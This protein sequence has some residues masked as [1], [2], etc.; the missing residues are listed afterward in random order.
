MN[1]EVIKAIVQQSRQDLLSFCVYTD[2]FYEIAP[3]HE[4]IAEYLDKVLNGEIQNLI[5]EMP[6]RSWKSR[7]MQ[8]FI[9]KLYWD[10]P[11]VDVLYTGHSMSLLEWFSRNIRNRINDD[12]YKTLYNTKVAWDSSAV[13]NWNIANGWE[14]AVFWVWGWITGKGWNIMVIDDPYS[15]REQAESET[16]R[17]KVSE[18]YW[19]TFLSR[20]QDDKSKQI[21]IMQRWREDDL[22]WEILEKEWDNWTELKIPALNEK[23]ESFWSSRFNADYF[24]DLRKKNPLFFASQYQQNP[25]NEEW[26]TFISDYF[27]YYNNNEY[28]K[29]DLEIVT[30]IDPAISTK[31]EADQ[32]AI[33]TIGLHT[34]SNMIYVL[35]VKAI[36]AEPDEIINEIFR[37]TDEYH[38]QRV[39]VEVVQYQK[40]LA[41]E[42]QK[43]MR[44]RN[45]YFVLEEINPM[46][47]KEARIKSILQPRYAN[48]S[49]LHNQS[50]E[51]IW[52]LETELLK[53]PKWKHDDIIDSLSW[54]VKMLDTYEVWQSED[55]IILN[56]SDQI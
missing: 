15:S 50:T 24:I 37:T 13:K 4:L 28:R 30:F 27:T 11:K 1:N 29:S 51:K 49:I 43:Q 54:A 23:E 12:T 31:Q 52:L 45:K 39:W 6:P 8:E 3:H 18:W 36:R 2:Q 41:L 32:T 19:S 46:W 40:M 21:I 47:E 55:N 16:I 14:F 26:G 56:F 34:R 53:F 44:L 33:V 22:V 10:T 5:I 20:K 48:R 35:E 38:P 17:R 42:I 9:A 7:I 25:V